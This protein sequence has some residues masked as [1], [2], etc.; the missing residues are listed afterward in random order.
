MYHNVPS[1]LSSQWVCGTSLTWTSTYGYT[2]LVPMN[3]RV[4]NMLSEERNIRGYK[5]STTQRELRLHRSKMSVTY[6]YSWKQRA[7][8]VITIMASWQHRHLGT[9][10]LVPMGERVLN[11]LTNRCNTSG[12]NWS[13]TQ[14]VLISHRKEVGVT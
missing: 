12:H 10:L 13:T 11:K 9:W 1:H 3:Q 6:I 4:L 14:R 5:W 2:L 7:S 8:S